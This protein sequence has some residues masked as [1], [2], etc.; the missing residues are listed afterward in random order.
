MNWESFEAY[1][2]KGFHKGNPGCL[3][4]F[5]MTWLAWNV[6]PDLGKSQHLWL[7]SFMLCSRRLRHR[8]CTLEL[9]FLE[10]LQ[11]SR[12][13][14]HFRCRYFGATEIKSPKS[15][16][17]KFTLFC[18]TPFYYM[19][20]IHKECGTRFFANL[21]FVSISANFEVD[22]PHCKYCLLAVLLDM[23]HINVGGLAMNSDINRL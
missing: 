15:G 4:L 17:Q 7:S 6:I 23:F 20:K 11:Q 22:V 18:L 2:R 1:L 21:C 16:T 3:S 10:F 14:E 13:H 9:E 19:L 8:I 12:N 5:L